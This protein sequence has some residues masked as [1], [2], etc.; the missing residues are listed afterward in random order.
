[1]AGVHA[2]HRERLR[3]RAEAAGLSSFQPHEVLELLLTQVI[4]QR[5]VN[6][7]AHTLIDA[8]GSVR[9][10]L[11]ASEEE[12]TRVPGIGSRTARWF[13][14]LG[15]LMNAYAREKRPPEAI[16]TTFS[17]AVSYLG[18]RQRSASGEFML[19]C[20]DN[21][22]R[23][24]HASPLEC[25]RGGYPSTANV[26]RLA[27]MHHARTLFTV[28]YPE[29]PAY[30]L[31]E[32]DAA[33]ANRLSDELALM[34]LLYLDHIVRVSDGYLSAHNLRLIERRWVTEP[35][36]KKAAESQSRAVKKR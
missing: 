17:E 20:V 7:L 31:R 13:R 24:T 23:V 36:A 18:R 11:S 25:E 14:C 34:D 2:G 26:A 22:G 5:D 30:A 27:L 21:S 16:V 15:E 32:E 9:A 29:D 28:R 3:A 33:F 1:M 19:V 12:L 6:Q 8:F 4:P 35:E 10:A